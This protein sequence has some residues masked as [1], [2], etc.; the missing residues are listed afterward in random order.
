MISAELLVGSSPN[1]DHVVFV[2]TDPHQQS[3]EE[4]NFMLLSTISK[5]L[6]KIADKSFALVF[7]AAE[8]FSFSFGLVNHDCAILKGHKLG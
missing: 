8:H 7:Q 3:L 5:I 2:L 1:Y 6:C 4:M